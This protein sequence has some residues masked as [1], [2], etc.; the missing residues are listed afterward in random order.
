MKKQSKWDSSVDDVHGKTMITVILILLLGWW[1]SSLA[2]MG[3][4][5]LYSPTAVP[6]PV[7]LTQ[8]ATCVPTPQPI[9][10]PSITQRIK[11]YVNK[12][13]EDGT[14]TLTYYM[15]NDTVNSW[16]PASTSVWFRVKDCSKSDDDRFT[17]YSNDRLGYE[18]VAVIGIVVVDKCLGCWLINYYNK[19]KQFIASGNFDDYMAVRKQGR[20]F[21]DKVEKMMYRLYGR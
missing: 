3:M 12:M 9:A 5:I 6:T 2:C 18:Q 17:R 1:I 10:T 19:D 7:I 21:A 16:D 13:Q 14:L 4:N 20:K 8:D 11:E 15:T